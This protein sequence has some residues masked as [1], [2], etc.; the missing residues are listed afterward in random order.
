MRK[1]T[2]ALACALG[3]LAIAGPAG[4][5]VSV[6]VNDDAGKYAEGAPQF[7]Q[8]MQQ[9]GLKQNAVTVL[10]DETQPTTTRR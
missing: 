7:W 4:A 1:F 2:A 6:G 8:T 3:A 10:W 5:G 9:N